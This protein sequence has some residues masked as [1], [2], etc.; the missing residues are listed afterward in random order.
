[1]N[2]ENNIYCRYILNLLYTELYT[3]IPY[4][5]VLSVDK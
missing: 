3:K 4:N 2:Y 1:M 5:G